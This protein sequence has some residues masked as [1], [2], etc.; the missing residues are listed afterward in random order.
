MGVETRGETPCIQCNLKNWQSF[1]IFSPKERGAADI[2][3]P[4]GENLQQ[5]GRT[6]QPLTKLRQFIL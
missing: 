6:L 1:A 2:A 3:V 5:G 4:T